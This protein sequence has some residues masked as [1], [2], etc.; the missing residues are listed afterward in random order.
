M[1][2]IVELEEVSVIYGPGAR[3]A[4]DRATLS[5]A[6]GEFVALVGFSGS[7]KTSLLKTVNRLVEPASGRVRVEGGDVTSLPAHELRRRIGYVF[8]GVGL[9]PHMSVRD[10][11]CITPA[12][13][14]WP[15]DAMRA[16]AADL[17]DLVAL[18]QAY[19]DRAPH[20]LSGGER[21][22]V[23]IA[24]ALAAEPKIVIMDEPFGALDPVTRDALGSAYRALHDRL[25]LTT[26]M[27]THDAQEAA[28]LA[29]RIVVMDQASIVADGA[30]ATLI[31]RSAAQG[32]FAVARRQAERMAALTQTGPAP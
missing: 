1:D 16:R 5:V 10:N 21:Q 23:A 32:M 12:L 15:K 26:L 29:G 18:P 30:P 31:A 6:R 11:I 28:L 7:G 14:G 27:V 24:R 9:F 3:P 8:Q 2:A 17:M 20:E 19:L 4:V 22:R 13:L 25:G